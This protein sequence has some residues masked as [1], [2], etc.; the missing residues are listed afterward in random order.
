MR[1]VLLPPKVVTNALRGVAARQPGAVDE[2]WTL[3]YPWVVQRAKQLLHGESLR[4]EVGDAHDLA[5][6]AFLKLKPAHLASCGDRMHLIRIATRAMRQAL[7]DRARRRRVA[8]VMT[9][10]EDV[11]P[12]ALRCAVELDRPLDLAL[13]LD[14]LQVV[15]GKLAEVATLHL[16]GGL[17]FVEVG[18]VLGM[19]EAWAR[20]VWGQAMGWLESRLGR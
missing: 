16:L 10:Y 18:R 12:Q 20:M 8:A 17:T 11:P 3:V 4:T 1:Q 14:A 6:E 19:S 13:A 5:H 2:V 15:N 9:S 7:V